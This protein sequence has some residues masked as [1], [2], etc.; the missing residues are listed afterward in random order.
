MQ[1]V[2][3]HREHLHSVLLHPSTADMHAS[4]LASRALRMRY[5]FPALNPHAELSQ[6][7]ASELTLA[8]PRSIA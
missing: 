5:N 4:A 3:L 2:M 8:M 1:C 7:A 6:Y